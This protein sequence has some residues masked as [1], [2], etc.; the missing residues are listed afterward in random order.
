MLPGCLALT[1][2]LLQKSSFMGA[3]EPAALQP[4]I[5]DTALGALLGLSTLTVIGYMVPWL[6]AALG[7]RLK[8]TTYE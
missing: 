5:I 6:A 1:L 7:R 8:V 4:Y 2:H 3:V